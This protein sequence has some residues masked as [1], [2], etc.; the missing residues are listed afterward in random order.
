MQEKGYL[1]LAKHEGWYSVSDEAFYPQSGVHLIVE[2][3]TVKKIMVRKTLP[4]YA[5]NTTADFG[6]ASIETGKEVEW[7]SES[8]YKFRLSGFQNRLL[9][10]YHNNPRFILP[11]KR[12]NDV[13]QSVSTGLDDLSVSR[14]VQRLT[15]GIPVP[16][17]ESQTIYVWLDALINYI[18]KAGFPWSPGEEHTGGWPAD[19]HV[20]GKDIVR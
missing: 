2:P 1:Y 12:M 5:A 15:W 11:P 8:N 3:S 19:C 4:S 6:K 16:T 10:F 9:E 17:D 14:P 7:T 20:I 13:V 18:T